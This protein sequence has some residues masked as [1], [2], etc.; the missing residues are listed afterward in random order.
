MAKKP[1]TK[2]DPR[3]ELSP[4]LNHEFNQQKIAARDKPR[5]LPRFLVCKPK[6]VVH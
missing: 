2:I 3:K 1:V 4:Y 5:S 6:D